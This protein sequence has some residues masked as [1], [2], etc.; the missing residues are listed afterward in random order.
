MAGVED[1]VGFHRYGGGFVFTKVNPTG[2]KGRVMA[3]QHTDTLSLS[4]LYSCIVQGYPLYIS[5]FL[6]NFG[7]TISIGLFRIFLWP[8]ILVRSEGFIPRGGNGVLLRVNKGDWSK[9][10]G[11]SPFLYENHRQAQGGY[12]ATD[13]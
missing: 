12:S 5:G 2:Y 1:R 4:S 11:Q 10:G 13:P 8:D 6:Y 9:Y 3:V 7:L